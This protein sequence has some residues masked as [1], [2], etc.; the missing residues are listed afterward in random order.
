MV[1]LHPDVEASARMKAPI[2]IRRSSPIHPPRHGRRGNA[3]RHRQPRAAPTGSRGVQWPPGVRRGG[4][5]HGGADA[6]VFCWIT[7]CSS[8]TPAAGVEQVL[9]QVLERRVHRDLEQGPRPWVHHL[10]PRPPLYTGGGGGGMTTPPFIR[11]SSRLT[12]LDEGCGLGPTPPG[13]P[14]LYVGEAGRGT[15]GLRS[16]PVHPADRGFS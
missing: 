13:R 4:L 16:C 7:G 14:P 3:R 12:T 6:Q 2:P 5:P 1:S 9:E 11:R 10:S 15:E 8:R